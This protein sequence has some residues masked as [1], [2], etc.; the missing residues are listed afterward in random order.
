MIKMLSQATILVVGVLA[1]G[2]CTLNQPAKTATPVAK[3][4]APDYQ[5]PSPPSPPAG[6]V[7]ANCYSAADLAT[8]HGRMLQAEL[9]VAY[10][11]CQNAGGSR[12]YQTHYQDFVTKYSAELAANSRA[13]SQVAARKRL[14]VDV[15][16]TEM[17]NRAAQRAP[18]DKEFCSRVKRAFDW[19]MDPKVT[20]LA[21]IPPPFDLGPEMNIYACPSP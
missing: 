8:V 6:N 5:A 2:G 16:V 15:F 11:Q 12:A 10:L 7:R 17:F 14:N 20:T 13:L 21:Q 19:S 9:N 4:A 1:M 18:V 3:A